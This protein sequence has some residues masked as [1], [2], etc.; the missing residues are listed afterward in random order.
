[1]KQCKFCAEEVKDEAIKCKHCGSMLVDTPTVDIM[2]STESARAVTKGLKQKEL[3][4]TYKKLMLFG[5]IL[6]SLF[7]GIGSTHA[8]WGWITLVIGGL[9]VNMWYYHE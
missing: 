9:L 2:A 5:V 1:M 6:I 7:V 3:H 4:G 8:S